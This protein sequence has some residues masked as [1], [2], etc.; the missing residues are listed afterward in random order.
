MDEFLC[1]NYTSI[2]LYLNTYMYTFMHILMQAGNIC[3]QAVPTSVSLVLNED[4]ILPEE[5]CH[6]SD[7]NHI[8]VNDSSTT[9]TLLINL[10]C[11]PLLSYS[12][13]H[14][15]NLVLSTIG[16]TSIISGIEFS[17][18]ESILTCISVNLISFELTLHFNTLD[19]DVVAN[20]SVTTGSGVPGMLCITCMFVPGVRSRFCSVTLED[21]KEYS[22]TFSI[23]QED[24][25]M[26]GTACIAGLVTGVY[27]ILVCSA[28]CSI[29][30]TSQITYVYHNLS[31]IGVGMFANHDYYMLL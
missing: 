28:N 18:Y 15:G 4:A 22:H 11:S 23:F 6:I 2:W 9:L 26:S 27:S 25:S 31:I 1:A 13:T 16:G 7:S 24:G 14:T 3:V 30:S 29:D 17:K 10:R 20:V 5:V 21:D 12:S 8:K 19:T